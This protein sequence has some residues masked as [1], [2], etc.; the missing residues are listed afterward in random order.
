MTL[1][2]RKLL[3][4]HLLSRRAR[5]PMSIPTRKQASAF[6]AVASESQSHA[7][8]PSWIPNALASLIDGASTPM[9][10]QNHLPANSPW[11]SIPKSQVAVTVR[12]AVAIPLMAPNVI[13]NLSAD[14]LILPMPNDPAQAGRANGSRLLTDTRTR[15]C[16][17]PDGSTSG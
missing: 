7:F 16:L 12:K 11:G 5:T 1:G 15:P 8:T 14:L 3:P 13:P 4:R 9:P 6:R 17:Q 10:N 2:R